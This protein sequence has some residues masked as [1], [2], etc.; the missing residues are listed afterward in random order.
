MADSQVHMYQYVFRS[1][2]TVVIKITYIRPFNRKIDSVF[3]V[4]SVMT[5]E[6]FTALYTPLY[7]FIYV[8]P[9]K[10]T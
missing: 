4:L 2:H 6:L 1:S 8:G 9:L 10:I 7:T 5:D 3:K